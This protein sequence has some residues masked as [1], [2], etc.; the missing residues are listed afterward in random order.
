[1]APR[2]GVGR[3]RR[4]HPRTNAGTPE[5][6]AG[7]SLL[8]RRLGGLR[9]ADPARAAVRRR[10]GAPRHRARPFPPAALAGPVPPPH[11]RGLPG[12]AHG[13]GLD[14]A[15]RPLRGRPRDRRT[16]IYASLRPSAAPDA[17]APPWYATAAMTR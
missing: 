1:M 13:R 8:C 3:S 12:R 14:R 7:P 6:L 9:R 16:P 4:R 5:A 2:L 11:L 10:G 15:L 17:A